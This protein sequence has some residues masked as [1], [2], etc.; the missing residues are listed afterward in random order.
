MGTSFISLFKVL[1]D[2][3]A[4]IVMYSSETSNKYVLDCEVE[5]R[6]W[7]N[8]CSIVSRAAAS[9]GERN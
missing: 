7:V 8:T 6:S 1:V 5:E 9:L 2:G 3:S 4:D